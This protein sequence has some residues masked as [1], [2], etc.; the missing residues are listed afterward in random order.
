MKCK[1]C[2]G[3]MEDQYDSKACLICGRR[4]WAWEVQPH[5]AGKKGK[6][7]EKKGGTNQKR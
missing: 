4:I 7:H 1:H 5:T 6:P 2:G 3:L